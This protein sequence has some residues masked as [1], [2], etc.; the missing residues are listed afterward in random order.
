M[1]SSISAACRRSTTGR[2]AHP[3]ACAALLAFAVFAFAAAPVTLPAARAQT[4]QPATDPAGRNAAVVAAQALEHARA[5][6]TQGRVDEALATIDEALKSAPRDAQLRFERGVLLARSGRGGE[7]I[8]VFRTLTRDFPELPEPYNNLAALH[9][10][11]GEL[12][13]AHRA[14]EDA[15]RALPSYALARENLGD[16]Q[17]RLA[18]RSYQQAIDA[19]ATNRS[20]REKLALTRELIA[21]IAPAPAGTPAASTAPA[22]R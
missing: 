8:D 22:T 17:L 12:D 20:A 3:A 15:L 16:V 6:A 14:L 7:A 9:A 5:Q 10:S 19:D 2:R 13:L 11:R 21:R 4:T 1:R 18:E